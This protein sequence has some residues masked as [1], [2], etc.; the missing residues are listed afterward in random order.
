MEKFSVL[1]TRSTSIEP[2]GPALDKLISSL[3]IGIKLQEYNAV[4]YWEKVVGLPIAKVTKATKIKK[5][6]LFVQV[7]TGTWRNELTL[8]KKEI[9][10]KINNLIGIDVV[11]DIRFL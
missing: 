1:K 8:R 7:K 10:D 2:I 5:G 6:V 4:V 11:K 3:G 9:I